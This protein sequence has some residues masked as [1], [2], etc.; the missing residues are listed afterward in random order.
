MKRIHLFL[1]TDESYMTG[2]VVTIV[3]SIVNCARDASLDIHVLHPAI[4]EKILND[5]RHTL[6]P[7]LAGR[8]TLSLD[9]VDGA[10]LSEFHIHNK[11]LSCFAYARLLIPVMYRDIDTAIYLDC[12]IIVQKDISRL[13]DIDLGDNLLAAV[14]DIKLTFGRSADK[15]VFR[16]LQYDPHSLYFNSGFLV[17]NLKKWREENTFERCTGLIRKYGE[18]FC[19]EDQTAL[20]L[21]AHKRWVMLPPSWNF[22][23]GLFPD[24]ARF[25]Y[26]VPVNYH[27]IYKFK[28]WLF[29]RDG[30]CEITRMFYEYLDM[31]GW[32]RHRVDKK[33]YTHKCPPVR[34]ET[35]KMRRMVQGAFYSLVGVFAGREMLRRA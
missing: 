34:N 12:D 24:K 2:A 33:V 6:E 3:S 10:G 32:E 8:H 1:A 23:T 29:N 18:L 35:R 30:Q 25:K 20:N 11:N 4:G 21:V 7:F 15:D 28:P 27:T 5:F 31:T 9:L 13:C 16:V 17:M 26:R 14:K 22:L 19:Q